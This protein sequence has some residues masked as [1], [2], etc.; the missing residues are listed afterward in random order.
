MSSKLRNLAQIF[1][2]VLSI[3]I[4]TSCTSKNTSQQPVVHLAIWGNYL[5][6][7]MIQKFSEQTGIKVVVSNYSSNEELLAKL[8]M[9]SS[10][11]D[12]A[13]PSDYMVKIMIKLGILQPLDKTKF[14]QLDQISSEL[15]AQ[16]FDQKN[17]FS[18]P[19][20]WTTTGIAVNRDLFKGKLD[21]WK[22]LL[23]NPELSG[24]LAL[25]DDSREVLGAALKAKG[26]SVNSTN[27]A[28]LKIARDLLINAKDRIKIFTS[29]SVDI[30]NNKE[31][32]AAQAFSSDVLQVVRNSKSKIEF[33]IPAE[34][35]TRAIDNLVLLKKSENQENAIKLMNFMLSP[36]VDRDR[37]VRILSGP[38]LKATRETLPSDIK[39]NTSLFP[40]SKTLAKLE[41]IQDLEDKNRLFEDIWT[42]IKSH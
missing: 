36:E 18:L 22:D 34:G 16:S 20:T 1:L 29:D 11:I 19:Y 15:M 7:E 30:L 38:A 41:R 14:H 24:K 25:L 35:S 17:E 13:V 21:S 3:F 6:P 8:Q 26:Y 5:S 32:V 42:D 9:G 40:D 4:A 12:V 23:E 28:E 27:K 2:I 33:I 37:V 39:N 31:V 10:G